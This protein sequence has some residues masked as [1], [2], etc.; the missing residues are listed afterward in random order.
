MV[1]NHRC[2][3]AMLLRKFVLL[4]FIM[5]SL[6]P[7]VAWASGDTL[8]DALI[9]TYQTNPRLQAQRDALRAVNERY[10]QASSGWRPTLSAQGRA[11]ASRQEIGATTNNRSITSIGLSASQPL[12]RGG[13][14]VAAQ[15]R[16]LEEINQQRAIL[17]QTEQEIFLQTVNAYVNVIRDF[18]VLRLNEKN[19]EVLQRN[20]E[21]TQDR[22]QV[23]EVTITDVAQ[24]E[25]RLAQA[26]A[27]TVRAL[28]NLTSSKANYERVVGR[29]PENL[30]KPSS[31]LTLPTTQEDALTVA[32]AENPRLL[33]AN[34]AR[35]AA[36]FAVNEQ[37]GALLPEVSAIASI[38]RDTGNLNG[39]S[40]ASQ[41]GVNVA[42]PIF[43]S[44]AE[45]SRIRE[46][47][48]RNAQQRS[49]LL[50][51]QRAVTEGVISAWDDLQTTRAQIASL[52]TSIT[53]AEIALEGVKQE[54]LVGSRTVLDVLNAEQELLSV[55]VNLVRAES[56]EILAQYSLLASMGRLTAQ[57]L[58]LQ[59]AVY[60]PVS[61]FE[62]IRGQW[63]GQGE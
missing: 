15:A 10:S 48:Q 8:T 61:D 55:R 16:A 14:T 41:A 28:G 42:V 39:S 5:Q 1:I 40:T 3:S 18:A 33:A 35:T 62:A 25:S 21:A 53:A 22:F 32:R 63:F 6:I 9:A 60:N 52:N 47:K 13:R 11:A 50:D 29:S 57:Y 34:F 51:E 44:G 59:T 2:S 23:G 37:Q 31:P 19:E 38:S 26:T 30:S 54:S 24:A 27:E 46:A 17:L 4:A 49:L 12:Y 20:L 58:Q 56:A 7:S 43:Q 36:S 45:Y